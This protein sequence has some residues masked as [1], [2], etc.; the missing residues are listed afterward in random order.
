MRRAHRREEN[1]FLIE[2]T[3][4]V[5]DLL[6]RN[7]PIEEVFVVEDLASDVVAERARSSGIPVHVV[8]WPVMKA[9]T[10]SVT[11]QGIVA[12]AGSPLRSLN[13]V[14]AKTG[15]IVILAAVS[16]PGNVGTLVR[17]AAAA[18]A[19][20]VILTE[21]S[22]DVMN[23]KTARAS[24][25]ALFSLPVVADVSL[26][27]AIDHVHTCGCAVVGT[28]AGA[29]ETIY[30]TDLTGPIALVLGNESWGVSDAE[31][32]L[33]DRALSI[34]MPGDVESLNVAVAGSVI[35]F[36]ALRQRRE[37]QEV[38]VSSPDPKEASG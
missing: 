8:G 23:P 32:S 14:V 10:D 35:L 17:S 33:L 11:P 16:D 21:G 31:R 28:D 24:A 13:T 27:Q 26:A 20:A 18:G 1:A 22:S 37:S 38:Q 30:S 6:D 5:T 15:L 29:P 19:D 36:E 25:S 7:A 4:S 9:I 12:V 3:R 2:G 34:P